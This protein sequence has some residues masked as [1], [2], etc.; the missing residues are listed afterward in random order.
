MGQLGT[1]VLVRLDWWW[2]WS[3]FLW[4]LWVYGNYLGDLGDGFSCS[5]HWT[6]HFKGRKKKNCLKPQNKSRN[7]S[8][9]LQLF[10]FF[11][12]LQKG[13][14]SLVGWYCSQ[15]ST[16]WL[17]VSG[18]S[19]LKLTGFWVFRFVYEALLSSGPIE[20]VGYIWR[21]ICKIF[22]TIPVIPL[23]L[24]QTDIARPRVS[25]L[26]GKGRAFT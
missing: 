22:F 4:N 14:T 18:F 23:V 26:D 8:L 11:G 7:W 13:L 19:T 3:E 20:A 5:E 10:L 9:V 21:L 1:W 17:M 12:V 24:F 2:D 6:N 15:S 16:W 25:L